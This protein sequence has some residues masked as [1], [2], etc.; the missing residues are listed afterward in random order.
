[1][2]HLHSLPS[3]EFIDF[4]L[5]LSI[6]EHTMKNRASNPYSVIALS[7][8]ELNRNPPLRAMYNTDIDMYRWR[9]EP[10]VTDLLTLCESAYRHPVPYTQQC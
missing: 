4:Y 9:Y 6:A 1:M 3:R 2:H 10:G 8:N 5:P 7:Y